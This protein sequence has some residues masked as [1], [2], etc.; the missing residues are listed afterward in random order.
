[1]LDSIYIGLTGL[2][3][4][5]KDLS[6]IGNNVAN[7][8]T[9]GFKSSQLVF[10]DLFYRSQFGDGG[11]GGDASRGNRLDFGSGLATGTTR[12]LFAQGEL[13]QS[14]N[15]QDVAID[16]NGFFV[17][18]RDGRSFYT[19]SG[20]FSFDADGWLVAEASKARVA[21]LAG[22]GLSDINVTGQR[23]NAGKATT[24]ASFTG[25]LNSGTAASAPFELNNVVVYDSVGVAHTVSLKLTNNSTVTA[26]SWLLEAR[27]GADKVV[28]SGE[29][30]FNADGTPAAGFNSVKL[31]LAPDGIAATEI[32]LN[33]GDPGTTAGVRSIAAASS[34]VQL[35]RQDGYA[36]GS[37]TKASFDDQGFLSLTYSNGQ[38]IK[39]ERLALASFTYLQGLQ[40][41]EGNL[42]E[43]RD[44]QPA[45]L[46]G[47]GEGV[48]GKIAPGRVELSNVEL[49]QEFGNLIISQRGYQASSQVISTANE[50][51]QQLFD[52]KARR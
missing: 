46:G 14:G 7:V 13:R 8:N 26:G 11:A 10:S 40:P 23:T 24:K 33:F 47:A 5:S 45:T 35:D 52:I 36:V 37:L 17:L 49:S 38:T 48:F 15:E 2:L 39:G 42:F 12:L 21:A 27:E 31:A 34:T 25:V 19:R 3:G 16:G 51:V 29:L 41:L 4:Y 1:M 9:T 20:Q 44:D 32:E 50:M 6:V 30:R 28:A 18:R 43:P 22:G